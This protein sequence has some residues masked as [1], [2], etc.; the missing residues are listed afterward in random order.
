MRAWPVQR[1]VLDRAVVE[2]ETPHGPVRIKVGQPGGRDLN[3]APEYEDVRARAEAAGV[4]FKQVWAE[5]L[6]AYAR[7]R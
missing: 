4:P 5:A 3:A 2:V 6:A 7:R 1:T